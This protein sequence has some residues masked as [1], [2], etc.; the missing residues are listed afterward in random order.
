[1]SDF[2]VVKLNPANYFASPKE[3]LKDQ[4]LSKEEK[5]Y[6]LK[7][8]AYDEREMAVAEE[9]NMMSNQ[10]QSGHILDEILNALIVLGVDSDED[11]PPPT[12]QG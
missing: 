8:W 5:I 9:E 2:D 4:S 6:I 3:I 10:T 11:R 1:M 12:K 7:Q